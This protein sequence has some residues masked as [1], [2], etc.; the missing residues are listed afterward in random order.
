MLVAVALLVREVLVASFAVALAGAGD[1]RLL[2]TSEGKTGTFLL[3]FAVPLF[4]GAAS[5]LSYAPLLRWPAWIFVVPGLGYSWYS[6][7]VQYF[8]FVR[9]TLA[10]R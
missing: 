7:L 1:Q 5:T 6:A 10:Q 9:R 3:M 4:L 2:V 8:P